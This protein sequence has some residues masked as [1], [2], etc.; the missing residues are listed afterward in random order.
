MSEHAYA[1]ALDI[2]VFAI[3]KGG[4]V[5]V[6]EEW[7]SG[8]FDRR[9]AQFLKSARAGGC[10]TFST[11]LGPDYNAAHANHFHMDFGR[12]GRGGICR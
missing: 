12:D 11:F 5:S 4:K 3:N 8:F 6:E 9:N 1:N 10:K 2:S 7:G